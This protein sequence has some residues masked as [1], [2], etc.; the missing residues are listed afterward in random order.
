MAKRKTLK[1]EL[2]SIPYESP[3]Y[4]EIKKSIERLRRLCP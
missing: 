3:E 1:E 4:K 2:E